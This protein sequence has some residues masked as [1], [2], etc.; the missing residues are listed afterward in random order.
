MF[1]M[2]AFCIV[3]AIFAVSAMF[4]VISLIFDWCKAEKAFYILTVCLG[5]IWL[6]FCALICIINVINGAMC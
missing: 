5:V 2:I 1:I 4:C 3:F 6:V